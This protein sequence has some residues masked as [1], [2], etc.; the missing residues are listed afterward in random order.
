MKRFIALLLVCGCMLWGCSAQDGGATQDT[1]AP[2]QE[3]QETT[4][5]TSSLQPHLVIPT[6][7]TKIVLS[8]TGVTVDGVPAGTD[9][10]DAVYVGADI[11]YYEA[12]HD[13]TYGNG[14]EADAHSA[15]EAKAHTVVTITQP[16]T[17]ILSGKLSAGQLAVDLGEDAETD[18]QAVVMLVLD[19]VDITC[20]VAP[21]VIFYRVYECGD[22]E[23][24]TSE[25]DTSAAGANV[26]LADGSVNSV[27]GSYVAKIYKPETVELNEAGDEVESAKKL[28]KYDGAFYSKMSMNI[29]GNDGILN[30]QAENEGLDSELH[31]SIYGGQ[32]N[33]TA[34]N[35]GINTNEDDV[36]VTTINGGTLNIIVDGSTGEGDAIDSNGYLV[37]NDGTV[38][39]AACSFSA[40]SGLD[41]DL[42]IY[43][44]GGT[45]I[46]TG[47]MYDQIDGGEQNY[48]VMTFA[49]TQAPGGTYILKDESGRE[50]MRCTPANSFSILVLSCPSLT[51]GTYTFWQDEIQFA[52]VQSQSGG[53]M[54]GGMG[55]K[56]MELPEDIDPSMGGQIQPPPDAEIPEQPP[57]NIPEGN[58][59]E[60][61]E[62]D[63]PEGQR[64]EPPEGDMPEGEPPEKPDGEMPEGAGPGGEM[65][66]SGEGS[67]E[68]SEV[69]SITQGGNFFSAVT[70]KE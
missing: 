6:E 53:M 2:T 10:S 61:P 47:N 19:G 68:S 38:N 24:S 12:G 44:N 50:V 35:D 34:G 46:A 51:E 20:T 3:T 7:G 39:V 40:D 32:I 13:F 14:S 65:P 31:L 37:I 23:V 9:A 18:P 57:E 63:M 48:V 60:K 21:A 42:G 67:A 49:Q 64:Q 26:A 1:T 4:A 54:P 56:P 8:D 16:G 30:I 41:S 27:T 25:V 69:F 5:P 43:I 17:Y 59:P 66:F 22:P 15:E 45:V 70:P 29:T 11:V 62:G 36:S 33:I 55:Q 58:P 28:H 52:A